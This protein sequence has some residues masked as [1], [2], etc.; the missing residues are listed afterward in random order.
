M[1]RLFTTLIFLL[2]AL[3]L[4]AGIVEKTYYFSAPK[5]TKR[6][7]FQK[8][9]F[10]NTLLTNYAGYPALPYAAVSLLL[11]PG[12]KAIKIEVK[13]EME[14]PLNGKFLLSPYQPSRTLNDTLEAPFVKN[15]K[16][17][18]SHNTLPQHPAG[19][20]K[21]AYMNG[22]GFA[23]TT[24]TPL[25]Y[26]PATGRVSYYQKV[27][28]KIMTAKDEKATVE[29]KN[30]QS[31]ALVFHK[32]LLLAQNPKA[33][34]K[35]PIRQSRSMD[36]YRLL[37]ITGANYLNS[38]DSLRNIYLERGLRSKVYS[39]SYIN[40][41]ISGQDS[42][43]KIRNFIIQEYQNHGVD[44]VLLGGD[45]EIVPYRGFY[46]YVQ[47][48]SGY[49]SNDI[50]ADL[51][52]SA[53]DGTWNDDGDNHWGEPDE[54]D[55]L[56]DVSVARMPFSNST[57][58]AN[59]I[60]KSMWYQNKPVLGEFTSPLLA[61]EFL[62]ADPETWGSDYLN[63]LI[64][65]HS[66]N[67]YTTTGIPPTYNIDSMYEKH[68]NWSGSDL[69]NAINQ[70][71]EF[72]HHVGHANETYVAHLSNSDI[73]DANFYAANGV[74]HNY[75]L[76][77]T[78]GCDCGAFDY[79]DCILERMVNIHNFA[80]AVIGNSRYGWFNEGQT[81]GPAAHLHREMVNALFYDS[82]NMIGRAF[83]Q[84][85]IATAPWVEAPG[86]WEEGALR[87]NFYDL[88]V[89][90]DPAMAVWTNEPITIN[91]TYAPTIT[92]GTD[93][94]AVHVEN[95]G[96]P[97]NNF[98]CSLM[99]DDD[100][101]G[102]GFTDSLGNAMVHFDTL[103]TTPGA[104]SLVV[105]G[106]NCMPDTN[107]VNFVPA[108]TAYVLYA[109]NV[110]HDSL[111]NNN[112]V[113]D[114][115]ETVSLNVGLDNVGSLDA[116][117]VNAQLSTLNE[118]VTILDDTAFYGT[119][120][121]S[122]TVWKTDAFTFTLANNVP[123]GMEI[124]FQIQNDADEGNWTSDFSMTANAP[125]LSCGSLHVDDSHYGNNNGQLDAGE[126]ATLL[127]PSANF[128]H[129]ACDTVVGTLSTNSPWITL[130]T[131]SIQLGSLG[132]DSTKTAPF[133]IDVDASTPIGTVVSLHYHLVSGAYVMDK[134]YSV[135]VGLLIEDFETGDF[136]KFEWQGAGAAPWIITG[137]NP[138]QG[139]WCAKSGLIG[140]LQH[141]DLFVTLTTA[142][143]DSIR[144]VRKVSSEE[145]YDFLKFYVDD[146]LID[147][148]SGEQDW[149]PVKYPLSEGSHT[150]L[151]SYEKDVS[152]AGGSDCA[153]LDSIVF[154]ATTVA[155]NVDALAKPASLSV[156]PNPGHGKFFLHIENSKNQTA[157]LEVYNMLGKKMLCKSSLSTAK[158]ISFDLTGVE[159]GIYF[160]AVHLGK[161][162]MTT[163]L[164]VE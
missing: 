87:W 106:Y 161:K 48:G 112:G 57:E 4:S 157:A 71:K 59:L 155:V 66:D 164:V 10:P 88:N 102:Y 76:F 110:L 45:V 117:N 103:V 29:A 78:H 109:A 125:A 101:I 56:P 140:D 8:I 163:K 61:G 139:L 22:Y 145:T 86:Q 104:G 75:T 7:D 79:N 47:S 50:P 92:I 60:H 65:T 84:A 33:L 105:V 31:N 94:L 41:H 126:T 13:G 147:Q 42:Q 69:I 35:Y 43:E 46:C 80:A 141:S 127:I 26:T 133:Q 137:N 89:L 143:D 128:G 36:D 85:K 9:R 124:S 150:L 99:K 68:Q 63:L 24:F 118:N 40:N 90:G 142:G 82:L 44:F 25:R 91:V 149:L 93:S 111:G 3:L 6:G 18:A 62:Y 83:V 98:T 5:I 21:T 27:T 49:E 134:D 12:E 39:V 20:L 144:F 64:G 148:W 113:P 146:V 37:I 73:T 159:S 54:D 30:L 151:W 132:I 123:D 55:L 121:A 120:V 152:M 16:V 14:T 119:I 158:G 122:D 162:V 52:Y 108:G 107:A 138:Y 153:W 100:L 160:V 156:F 70:G 23:L 51:Y 74:T 77:H 34:S 131:S 19:R 96:T 15:E 53:L 2:S 67:G 116:H 38:F 32:V 72:V 115:G 129:A 136:S 97:M 11:P 58:L 95:N 114:F 135:S 81:E 28:V 130:N 1:K 17:Y 154:P